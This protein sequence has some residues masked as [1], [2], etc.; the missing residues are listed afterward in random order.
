MKFLWL[1]S[2]GSPEIFTNSDHSLMAVQTMPYWR[3][4]GRARFGR[5]ICLLLSTPRHGIKIIRDFSERLNRL[6]LA[7]VS[8]WGPLAGHY[9]RP[10]S[11]IFLVA[12]S[13]TGRDVYANQYAIDPKV[14]LPEYNTLGVRVD[15]SGRLSFVCFVSQGF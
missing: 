11:T 12:Q 1:K 6:R 14:G 8:Q 4:T 5:R 15:T 7:N 3:R 2:S 10:A 13:L 9:Y